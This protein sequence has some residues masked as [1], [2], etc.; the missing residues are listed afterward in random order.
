MISIG[1][2][3]SENIVSVMNFICENYSNGHV[4][5]VSRELMDWQYKD[6]DYYNFLLA[7]DDDQLMGI[8]GYIPTERYD[9]DLKIRSII[10]PAL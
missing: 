4:L 2:C 7:W 8:L 1:R 3:K 10:F 6:G 5:S 9:C